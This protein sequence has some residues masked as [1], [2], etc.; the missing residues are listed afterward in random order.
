M[1]KNNVL[2]AR[3]KRALLLITLAALSSAAACKADKN[4]TAQ[5]QNGKISVTVTNFPP[6]DFVRQIAGDRVNLN[7]LLPPG[8]ESHSDRKS[9][10]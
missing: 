2:K 6:Y 7:M 5:S 8:S 10:V 9:V 3:F 1:S 4:A